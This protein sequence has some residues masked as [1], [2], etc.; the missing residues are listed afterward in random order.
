M[1]TLILILA[2]MSFTLL[3]YEQEKH[4]PPHWSYEGPTGP[5]RWGDLN[6]DY[7]KC[8]TGSDQSPINITDSVE[9]DLPA[10]EFHYTETVLKIID[11]GHTVQVN[12]DGR[13]SMTVGGKQYQLLQFHFH[14]PS[15]EQMNGKSHDMVIH[16]VHQDAEEHKAVIAVLVDQGPSNP[17]L[18]TIFNHL[19]RAS[20]GEVTTGATINPAD[21]LP[22]T[23][24]YYTFPGSLTTPPCSEG[25]TWFVL[26]Q[27]VT[28][29]QFELEQF[30]KL[31]PHNARP[32]QPL[33]QR[34]VLSTR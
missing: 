28:L 20:E 16:L 34:T 7:S 21:L 31:Y 22:K 9:A 8:K 5:D 15:E 1:R 4:G 10:I 25:V 14:H 32:V 27:P 23:G 26:K 19:P 3:S 18:K 33:H 6:S 12:S 11:N 13:S 30:V 2:M 29:S 24:S 17:V